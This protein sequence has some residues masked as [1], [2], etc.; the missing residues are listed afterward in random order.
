MENIYIYIGPESTRLL[1]G[2]AT[3]ICD[4]GYLGTNNRQVLLFKL[5]SDCLALVAHVCQAGA[6]LDDASFLSQ[7][8]VLS[9][10]YL[11]K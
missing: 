5:F 3:N 7:T 2:S 4:V 6:D 1:I 10:H 8:P 9:G 11:I